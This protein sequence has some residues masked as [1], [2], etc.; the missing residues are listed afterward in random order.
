M[1]LWGIPSSSEA[2]RPITGKTRCQ[3]KGADLPTPRHRRCGT[4]YHGEA[5]SGWGWGAGLGAAAFGEKDLGADYPPLCS[6]VLLES[7]LS[8]V[9][10]HKNIFEQCSFLRVCTRG[11]GAEKAGGQRI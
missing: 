9:P 3:Q 5:L 11:G 7:S 8:S 1:A 4:T 2:G 6:F 10:F